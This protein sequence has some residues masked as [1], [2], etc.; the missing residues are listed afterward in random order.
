MEFAWQIND[1]TNSQVYIPNRHTFIQVLPPLEFFCCLCMH[2]SGM[3]ITGKF[4]FSIGKYRKNL[5]VQH[6]FCLYRTVPEVRTNEN[7]QNVRI[8][9]GKVPKIFI[10]PPLFLPVPDRR[11]TVISIPTYMNFVW[12]L[13]LDTQCIHH[14]DRSNC[15]YQ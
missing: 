14:A 15:I 6:Y 9:A 11:T 10:C 13:Q 7:G 8:S 12:E 4:C 2:I 5:P 1:I 3:E